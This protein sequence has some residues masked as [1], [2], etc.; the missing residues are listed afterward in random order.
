MKIKIKYS[1]NSDLDNPCGA[2]AW[3][4]DSCISGVGKTWDEAKK[5]L[6][7]RLAVV[8]TQLETIPPNEETEI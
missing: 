6:L 8:A 1:A 3:V 2:V 5:S 4:D 7:E